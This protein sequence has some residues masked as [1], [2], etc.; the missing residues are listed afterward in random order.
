MLIF[1]FFC[2]QVTSVGIHGSF[3]RH[4]PASPYSISRPQSLPTM[5]HPQPHRVPAVRAG[6]HHAHCSQRLARRIR[7]H[8]HHSRTGCNY[9]DNSAV[10]LMAGL[11]TAFPLADGKTT[12]PDRKI[13]SAFVSSVW[14][15]KA[16]GE[17]ANSQHCF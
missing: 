12:S 16:L 10:C 9:P 15:N 8:V 11:R 3:G 14:R 17:V 5:V 13:K 1:V 2:S 4:V 6:L 7:Q